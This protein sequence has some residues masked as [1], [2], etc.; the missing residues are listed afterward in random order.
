MEA[1]G[2]AKAKLFDTPG[3]ATAVLNLDDVAGMR[4]ARRLDGRG[5]R[6]IG[7][8]PCPARAAA[9]SSPPRA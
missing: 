7:Y 3:L 4:L 1:Y 2:E 6:V 8:S 5:L 9:N